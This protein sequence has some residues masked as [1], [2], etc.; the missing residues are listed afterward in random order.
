MSEDVIVRDALDTYVPLRPDRLPAWSD[1]VERAGSTGGAPSESRTLRWRPR[2]RR[3]MVIA[4][5]VAAAL[6]VAL[7]T[8]SALAVRDLIVGS[9]S[10]QAGSPTWSSDGRRIAYVVSHDGR[11]DVYVMNADGSGQRMLRR[12]AAG[13]AWSP[14][15]RKL[16]FIGA[17]GD[18]R[19]IVARPDVYV[20]N[21]GG[22]GLRKLAHTAWSWPVWLP[23]G[24][25]A[26]EKGKG[27]PP[28][29]WNSELW[30]MNA[31]GSERRL[32]M[33]GG[34]GRIDWSPDGRS[35][36]L[37][38][39]PRPH[40]PGIYVMNADG[41]GRRWLADGTRPLWSP[42]GDVIA[43]R[44]ADRDAG[45]W[46][47]NADGSGE[48]TLTTHLYAVDG[49]QGYAW[50]PDG[51]KIA[52]TFGRFPAD[53]EN[54]EIYVMNADGSGRRNLTRH[55]GADDHAAWSPD[56]RKIAFSRSGEIYVMNADGSG[57]RN[58]SEKGKAP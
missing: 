47:I 30:V 33:S 5:A 56:G 16:A 6:V 9:S 7:G 1:V 37:E 2:R 58:L 25:L 46:S 36:A 13:P 49:S 34:L 57:Q 22:G 12:N 55:G 41:S 17:H 44:A 15:G 4:F 14:D 54:T 40:R 18:P 29:S 42:R 32:V 39:S 52:F 8:A 20:W 53:L 31:D 51:R 3:R 23:D 11:D 19:R 28:C 50:S 10:A 48:R 27:C 45:L 35:I 24:R 21:A 38:Y 26:I 43:F